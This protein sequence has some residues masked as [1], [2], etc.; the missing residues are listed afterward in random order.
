MLEIREVFE[1]QFDEIW[2]IFQEVVK[3]MDSY[4]Y[5]PDIKKEEAKKS[6][7]APGSYVYIAYLDGEPVATRYIMPNRVGLGSH[8]ANTAV[9]IAKKYRRKGLGKQMMEFAIN[10]SRELG[11]K[12]IQLNFVVSTNMSAIKICQQYDFKIVGTL[13]NAFHYKQEKYVD[14][15][16][17]YKEL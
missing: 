15:Y 2:P 8:I 12:A 6:W 17:M 5:Y 16:V 3:D 4:A 11:F 13:P 9:M 10:K 14:A 7:F 1:D